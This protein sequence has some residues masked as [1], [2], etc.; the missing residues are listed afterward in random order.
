MSETDEGRPNWRELTEPYR[1]VSK[2]RPYTR[3]P[4]GKLAKRRAAGKRSKLA[5][6]KQRLHKQRKRA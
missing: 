5:R 1:R 6:R 3:N 4:A 2:H